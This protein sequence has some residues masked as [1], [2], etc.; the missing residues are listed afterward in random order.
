MWTAGGNDPVLE[1]ILI[2][3]FLCVGLCMGSF[4][5]AISDRTIKGTSW[6]GSLRD[7]PERSRCPICHHGLSW[8]E[9]IPLLSWCLL[10]GRC[11]HCHTG[12]SLLYPAIELCGAVAASVLFLLAGIS[13]VCVVH[14]LVLPFHLAVLLMILQRKKIPHNYLFFYLSGFIAAIIFTVVV[15][16]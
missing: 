16:V 15:S 2:Y 5:S 7:G 14:L 10:R 8:Y 6:I 12:I 11:R 13:W 1:I 9:L 4:A 3:A